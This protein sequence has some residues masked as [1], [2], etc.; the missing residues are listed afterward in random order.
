MSKRL[1]LKIFICLVGVFVFFSIGSAAELLVP[2]P[3]ADP[4]TGGDPG[5]YINSVY[6]WS[7]GIG[8]L[9]ALLVLV[10]GGIEY[11]LSA[12]SVTSRESAVKRIKNAVF[13]LLLLVSIA[14]ILATINPGLLN[15]GL[16]N[17]TQTAK[18]AAE[19]AAKRDAAVRLLDSIMAMG[20]PTNSAGKH[21]LADKIVAL[22]AMIK[23]PASEVNVADMERVVSRITN[24]LDERFSSSAE[25]QQMLDNR[26]SY[27]EYRDFCS[28]DKYLDYE[29]VKLKLDNFRT[30]F[31]SVGG[32]TNA[33]VQAAL[34]DVLT[35]MESSKNS[36]TS[37]ILENYLRPKIVKLLEDNNIEQALKNAN[38][39]ITDQEI[40]QTI[41]GIIDGGLDTARDQ[42]SALYWDANYPLSGANFYQIVDVVFDELAEYLGL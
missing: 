3:G 16:G 6:T 23:D 8:A 14:L 15:I 22:E 37:D 5:N 21:A 26:C 17:P 27:D 28:A 13:G 25:R 18:D 34:S 10:V 39:G 1:L 11:T 36:L 29:L 42:F 9:L 31:L 41:D 4:T 33:F 19:K 30:I 32:T 20:L 24:L 40:S 7:I 12:G 38:P 35:E 2:I